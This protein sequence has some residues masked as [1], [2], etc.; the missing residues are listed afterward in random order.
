MNFARIVAAAAA[1]IALWASSAHALTALAVSDVKVLQ[2]PGQFTGSL[3][4]IP[5]GSM[6][7]V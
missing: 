1:L 3:R 2:G 6:V 4:I 5:G 7:E